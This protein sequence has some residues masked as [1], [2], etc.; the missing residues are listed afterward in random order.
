MWIV[1]GRGLFGWNL[2]R[3]LTDLR[4]PHVVLGRADVDLAALD[5]AKVVL[6]RGDV[7]VNAAGMTDVD[8]CETRA[9][10]A[11]RINAE[12]PARLAAHA[13]AK[14]ARFVHI[15]SDYVLAPVNTYAR[16]KAE[17][18]R[19]VLASHP[20]ALLL[21]VSTTFG[22]HPTKGDFVQWVLAKL[23]AGEPFSV[24][25]D[26]YSAPTYAPDAARALATLVHKGRAG[27]H[28]A[29][30]SG[31]IS[32]HAFALKVQ[33]AWKIPGEIAPSRLADATWFK[34]PRAPDTSMRSTVDEVHPTMPLEACLA[35]YREDPWAWRKA[36]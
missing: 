5:L 6:K 36:A 35:A 33:E 17:G 22:P 28:Q 26:L 32:R 27:L 16:S 14:G 7:L 21:R 19:L 24:I 12:A 30:N 2:A 4:I 25:D 34:A 10:E 9:D 15:S 23:R 8:A 13:A 11:M 18:E 1:L 3:A 31:R 29:V 20:D